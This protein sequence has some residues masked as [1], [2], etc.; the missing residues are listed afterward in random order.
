MR[1]QFLGAARTVTGSCYLVDTKESRFLV[2][3]GLFQGSRELRERNYASF[4]FDPATIDF[5]ILSHAHIDHSGMIPKLYRHGFRG[6]IYSTAATAD[7]CEV[8]L[9]DSAHIQEME[10]E[11]INR[12]NKRAGYPEISPIYTVKDAEDCL[13]LFRRAGYAETMTVTPEIT[14]RFQ[15]AG[16]ILGSSLI[17]IWAQSEGQ[18]IKLVFSGDVGNY[19]RPL[20]KDPTIIETA[21]YLFLESTY[22]NRTHK[23]YKDMKD[24]FRDIIVRTIGRGGKVIIPAFAVERTQ[25][26]IYTLSVL[27]KEQALPKVPIIIDSP[28]AIRATEVFR[29]HLKELDSDTQDMIKSGY[30]PFEIPGLRYS[31]T[32]EESKSL[33]EMKGGAIIISASGMADAGRIKHHLKHNLWRPESAVVFVGYQAEGTL[34]R[35]ILDGE[36]KVRIHGEDIQVRAQIY[37]LEGFSGHSDQDKLLRWVKRF[38]VGPGCIF[39]VHGE[40]EASENLARLI[41]EQTRIPT[42]IPNWLEVVELPPITARTATPAAESKVMDEAEIC[43]LIER[44]YTQLRLKLRELVERGLDDRRYELTLAQIKDLEEQVV[45]CTLTGNLEEPR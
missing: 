9:P 35:R 32:S 12:K 45:A 37:N 24:D 40:T 39:I 20:M 17:E 22:G 34:G 1:I 14:V 44:R 15:D 27:V 5:L 29:R 28:L 11:R 33:N 26:L 21:D 23:P 31:M 36:K 18:E 4:M 42:R 43:A 8:M 16:H 25:D 19:N 10:V 3:C 13:K 2:D 38:R 6:P 7:L 30:N 41:S